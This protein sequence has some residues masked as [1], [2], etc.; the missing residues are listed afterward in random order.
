MQRKRLGQTMKVP[1]GVSQLDLGSWEA[2]D[3]VPS[4]GFE[5]KKDILLRPH[6]YFAVNHTE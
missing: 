3:R 2:L 6:E 1:A 5:V 4:M